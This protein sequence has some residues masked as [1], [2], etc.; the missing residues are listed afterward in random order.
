MALDGN[1][2]PLFKERQKQQDPGP[3]LAK[4]S[5][6]N[7]LHATCVLHGAS[8]PLA[9]DLPSVKSLAPDLTVCPFGL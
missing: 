3:G 5:L 2:A 8:L 6:Q 1:P 7:L 4:S 9:A